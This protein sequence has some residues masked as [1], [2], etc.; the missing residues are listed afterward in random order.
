MLFIGIIAD[1]KTYYLNLTE[2][3]LMAESEAGDPKWN[4]EYSMSDRY[5]LESFNQTEFNRLLNRLMT[6]DTDLR[7]FYF[8]YYR[9]SDSLKNDFCDDLCKDK[10]LNDIMIGNPYDKSPKS[11]LNRG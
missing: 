9:F 11:V 1:I 5:S 4:F 2:A 3:N 6:N 8:H 7:T 10:F